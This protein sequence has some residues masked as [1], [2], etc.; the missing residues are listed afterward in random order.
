MFV[1]IQEK[2]DQ[3][4]MFKQYKYNRLSVCYAEKNETRYCIDD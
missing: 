4:N 2:R 1:V 3:K